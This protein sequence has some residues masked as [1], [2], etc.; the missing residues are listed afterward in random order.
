MTAATE[1][2]RP[3]T[4]EDLL[5]TLKVWY[6]GIDG[7]YDGVDLLDCLS[8]DLIQILRRMAGMTR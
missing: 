5:R 3:V 6:R 4:D 1:P 8:Y 7:E 2:N